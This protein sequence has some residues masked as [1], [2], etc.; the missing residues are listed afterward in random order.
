MCSVCL[1]AVRAA[2][3]T[4]VFFV[5]D[6]QARLLPSIC[7]SDFSCLTFPEATSPFTSNTLKIKRQMTGGWF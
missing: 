6:F 1:Q 7:F 5:P 3:S 2:A 4:L